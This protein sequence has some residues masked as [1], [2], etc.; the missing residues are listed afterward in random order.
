MWTPYQL[1]IAVGMVVTGSINTLATKWADKQSAPGHPGGEPHPFDHPFLQAVCM[2]IGEFTCFI[3]YKIWA[4]TKRNSSDANLGNQDFSP[5]I[6]L[7]PAACDM[8]GTSLMY[9]GLNFTFASSFQ[10]LRGAIIVFTALLSTAF[11]GRA[12]KSRDWL[13]IFLV[14]CGLTVVGVSDI[15]FTKPDSGHGPNEILTGDLIILVAQIVS[16]CQ[17]VIEEKFVAGK[18]VHPLQAV[19]WE[20]FFGMTILGVLLIPMYWIPAGELSGNPRGVLEDAVDGIYQIFHN[21]TLALAQLGSIASIAFFNFFGISVT[22]QLSATTRMVLDSVRTLVIWAVG[23]GVGWEDFQY[24]QVV[25]FV[26]LI[27]GTAVYNKIIPL[28]CMD[29]PAELIVNA[30]ETNDNITDD[31]RQANEKTP[32]L[33]NTQQDNNEA[34]A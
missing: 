20:G 30:N 26:T 10:M 8:T 17:M 29:S 32:L 16:A 4:Y 28:P 34:D 14:T 27:M 6:F 21:S 3:V 33:Y 7:A 25:G 15:I 5:L 23:L 24:L 19:G 13:G 12:I 18:D 2:F 31:V 9:V 1:G 22:K 11:L